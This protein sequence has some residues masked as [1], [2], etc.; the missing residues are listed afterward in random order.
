MDRRRNERHPIDGTAWFDWK[1]RQGTRQEQ[2][3]RL[4]NVSEG[5]I[6]VETDKPPPVGTE[7][8]IEFEFNRAGMT[9]NVAFKAKGKI[10]RVEPDQESDRSS[11]FAASTGRMTLHKVLQGPG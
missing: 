7:I 1:D 5:G 11:G 8:S 2:S 6:F 10:S 4:R 9:P 3:G